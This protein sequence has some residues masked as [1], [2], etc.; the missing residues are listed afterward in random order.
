MR[1]EYDFTGYVVQPGWRVIDI[2]ANVGIFTLLCS[3][4]GGRIVSYEPSPSS[5]DKLR[6][7][8]VGRWID[9]IHAAVVPERDRSRARLYLRDRHT[10]NSL[11]ENV[12]A[13]VRG[14]S[15]DIP[16][17]SM[18]YVLDKPCDLLKIDTEG[19]EQELIVSAG[20]KLRNAERI[21]AEIDESVVDP[22]IVLEYVQSYGF[23][24][25]VHRAFPGTPYHLLTVKK[26]CCC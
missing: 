17:V 21:I 3:Q 25:R 11:L 1:G 10:R 5:V 9:V 23:G 6:E 7:H 19:T 18:D 20:D 15:I 4:R 2:G 8:S 26:R 14:G 12:G 24:G 16:A 22:Q 13:P